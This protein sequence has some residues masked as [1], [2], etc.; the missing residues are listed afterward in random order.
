MFASSTGGM[1]RE[2]VGYKVLPEQVK[3]M[4]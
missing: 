1:K 2:L 3:M 4:P